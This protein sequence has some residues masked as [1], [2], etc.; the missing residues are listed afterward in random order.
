MRFRNLNSTP[1]KMQFG[2]DEPIVIEPGGEGEVPE[3]WVPW[4]KSRGYLVE[5]VAEAPAAS[6]DAAG[7]LASEE[8]AKRGRGRRAA[9]SEGGEPSA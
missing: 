7:E 6:S 8:P 4:V 3:R 5:P 1:I 2:H 9:Q